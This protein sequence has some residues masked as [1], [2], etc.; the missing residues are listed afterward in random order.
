MTSNVFKHPQRPGQHETFA[1][2]RYDDCRF[3]RR[4][5]GLMG[6]GVYLL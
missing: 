3:Q 6:V 2:L 1:L 5:V 4:I